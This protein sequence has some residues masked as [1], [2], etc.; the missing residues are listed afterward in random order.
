MNQAREFGYE[1]DRLREYVVKEQAVPCEERKAKRDKDIHDADK[2]AKKE[3]HEAELVAQKE[4]R[5]AD[6]LARKEAR[7]ARVADL[8]AQKGAREAV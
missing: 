5:E 1:G 2:A 6:L 8:L 4:A 3:A 7:E